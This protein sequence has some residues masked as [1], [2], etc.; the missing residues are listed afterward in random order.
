MKKRFRLQKIIMSVL[1][2]LVTFYGYGLVKELTTPEFE[3]E[4]N[5]NVYAQEVQVKEEP[6]V[7]KDIGS[8]YRVEG[9]YMNIRKEPTTKSSSLGHALNGSII[10]IS[11]ISNDGEWGYS[12]LYDGW[13]YLGLLYEIP[14]EYHKNFTIVL[15][16]N[17]IEYALP[18]QVY[19]GN[20]VKLS[21]TEII[22]LKDVSW[23]IKPE[24]G[25]DV[26]RSFRRNLDINDIT[27]P[28]YLSKQEIKSL[29]KGTALEGIEDAVKEIEDK[30]SVNALYTISVAA[31][32]S[33][34]GRSHLARTRN[35]LFGIAAYD[36]NV[37]AAYHFKS[38]SDCVL[39]W[40][41]MIKEQYFDRGLK[42]THS[43]NTIYA[44]DTRW[45][46]KV[47]SIMNEC[48]NSL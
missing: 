47:N 23:S 19:E 45:S 40:G 22:N 48:K 27:K 18:I 10:P 32:E 24:R 25:F 35:N 34:W 43:I 1:I 5:F 31:H 42:T 39:Y 15:D 21:K 6:L 4:E 30:Y 44:S 8:L 41:K 36:S 46:H 11:K 26:S 9:E 13:F 16:I 29:I 2:L 12:N 20:K 38:K 28:S 33:G 37:S 3:M 7:L 17:D 14:K